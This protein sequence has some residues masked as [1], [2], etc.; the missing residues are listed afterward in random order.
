MLKC[1]GA[2]VAAYIIVLPYHRE[3]GA[4]ITVSF[5]NSKGLNKPLQSDET[6]EAGKSTVGFERNGATLKNKKGVYM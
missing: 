3:S 1:S 2:A 6:A 5:S 4:E